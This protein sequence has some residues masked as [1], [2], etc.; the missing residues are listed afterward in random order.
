MYWQIR[1]RNAVVCL[2]VAQLAATGLILSDPA[3]AYDVRAPIRIEGDQDFKPANGVVS[4]DGSPGNPYV[5][6]GWIISA[7]S[8]TGIYVANTTACFIVRNVSVSD[9]TKN[10][11]CILLDNCSNAS[12]I[13]CTTIG[14]Y[15][16]IAVLNGC[17]YAI[18]DLNTV[19]GASECGIVLGQSSYVTVSRNTA[20]GNGWAG[21]FLEGGWGV[22]AL[23]NTMS[24]NVDGINIHD[25]T[26]YVIE[27][28]LILNLN[29]AVGERRCGIVA[30][31]SHNVLILNNTVQ[32]L[33]AAD[34]LHGIGVSIQYALGGGDNISV[35]GNSVSGWRTG[36]GDAGVLDGMILGNIVS[37][38]GYGIAMWGN[39]TMIEGNNLFNN[40]VQASASRST[41]IY[42]NSSYPA[43]G[44]YWSDYK[45]VDLKSGPLQDQPGSDGIG[46][47]PYV[48]D[49]NNSDYYPLYNYTMMP[50]APHAS[51]TMSP[52]TGNTRTAY[53]FDASSCYDQVDAGQELKVRWDWEG[54]GVWDTDWTTTKTANH[55]YD[56]SGVYNVSV[57]VMNSFGITDVYRI[58][59][60]VEKTSSSGIL[61]VLVIAAVV[62]VAVVATARAVRMKRNKPESP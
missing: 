22:T 50:L 42:W 1:V 8:A 39:R 62:F 40:T 19:A 2:I 20:S 61:W 28:N 14:G 36:I 48:I 54:D 56:Q 52:I 25:A 37:H 51:F 11:T 26:D 12:V 44:N 10:N 57:E 35:I 13:S 23:N 38:N 5:I 21:A 59:I 24:D 49:A 41:S 7:T 43:G 55:K 30:A 58:Q 6:E 31:C 17:D 3:E 9:P 16:G 29:Q 34:D 45:G 47:T 60:T 15:R 46:D 53:S 4:G 33:S 32:N 27:D 18:V